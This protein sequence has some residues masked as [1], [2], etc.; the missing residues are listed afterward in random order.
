ML[1]FKQ[2]LKCFLRGR[3]SSRKGEI[4][5]PADRSGRETVSEG[6]RMRERERGRGGFWVWEPVGEAR[7]NLWPV[8]SPR[9]QL[10]ST[11]ARASAEG[12]DLLGEQT[13]GGG[14]V[15]GLPLGGHCDIFGNFAGPVLAAGNWPQWQYLH[16]RNWP[17]GQIRTSFPF[18]SLLSFFVLF[19]F[20]FC[21]FVFA[22]FIFSEEP[23]YHQHTTTRP[24]LHSS[25]LS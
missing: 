12:G 20:C 1:F 17:T 25:P 4:D 19:W 15:L 10:P 2:T 9:P 8:G 13:G 5:S 22:P 6:R 23:G 14:C 3:E 21:F 7:E 11:S 16:H 24:G 18:F